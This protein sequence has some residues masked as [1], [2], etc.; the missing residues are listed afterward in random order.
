LPNDVFCRRQV[1]DVAM[2]KRGQ[3]HKV[4]ERYLT[5]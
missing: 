5:R 3:A 2:S 1:R 4:E